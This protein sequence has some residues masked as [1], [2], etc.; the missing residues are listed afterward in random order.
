L[1]F[2]LSWLWETLQS[3]VSTIQE[4]F[5]NIW[6]QTQN[7][8]NT[9]Q[10]LFAGLTAFASSL[11][12]AITKFASTF[13][14][15][16]KTAYNYI[17]TGLEEAMRTISGGLQSA[18]TWVATGFYYIASQVV[19]FGHNLGNW[20][21]SAL[22]KAYNWLVNTVT[23]IWNAIVEWF[24]GIAN[25]LGN[26]WNNITGMV[27]EWWTNLI[28]TFRNK[29]KTMISTNIAVTMLWKVGERITNPTSLKDLGF[30]VLGIFTAP[31]VGEVVG[32]I[33]DAVIPK[34]TTSVFPLLPE[35]PV[36]SYTPPTIS[37]PE[38]P[39]PSTPTP[40]PTPPPVTPP[41]PA[42]GVIQHPTIPSYN[43]VC[44]MFETEKAGRG[45][46]YKTLLNYNYEIEIITVGVSQS[47]T[48]A[49]YML[50]TE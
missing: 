41:P 17:K 5:S 44:Y 40:A 29:I 30:G 36:F 27:N 19:N 49:N 34:P 31:I 10:G 45:E 16:L 43:L 22:I 7:I 39:T 47:N 1:S 46:E 38:P 15:A 42:V 25:T 4:W 28:L 14:D 12:D 35:V 32:S 23:T 20:I 3:V 9:G 37:I 2:D 24:N 6:E 13:S 33:V 18:F 8:T 26:W 11:W 50:T 48:L 21:W